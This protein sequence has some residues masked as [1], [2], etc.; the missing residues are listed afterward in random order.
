MP[1]DPLQAFMSYFAGAGTGKG[2][3]SVPLSQP[4]A[5][6]KTLTQKSLPIIH[7]VSVWALVA[8]FIFWMEPEAFRAQ[9]S[10]IVSSSTMLSRWA[11]LA[12]GSVEGSLWSVEV[13]PFFWAF[14]SLELALHSIRFF[15]GF[16]A[17]QLPMLLSLALPHLPKR[18]STIIVHGL[19]YLRLAGAILDD[20]AAAM[21]AIGLFIVASH[22]YQNWSL[23]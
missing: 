19:G 15:S 8:F 17:V 21:V 2:E 4:E 14:V 6:P 18:L 13:V 7:V 12:T 9:N 16:D 3:G 20:L 5:K 11:R 22:L 1:D 10:A 23:S